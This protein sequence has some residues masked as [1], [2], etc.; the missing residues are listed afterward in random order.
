MK[1]HSIKSAKID[2]SF[3]RLNSVSEMSERHHAVPQAWSACMR[4]R[5]GI[6]WNETVVAQHLRSG[7]YR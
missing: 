1:C 3:S 7:D 6:L 2:V 4:L 5:R